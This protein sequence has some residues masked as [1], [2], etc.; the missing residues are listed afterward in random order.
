MSKRP[1]VALI[2]EMSGIYGRQ[3]LEGIARYLRSHR[4]WSV[5][6]EQRELRAPPPPWCSRRH[7][8]GIICRS[9]TRALAR[10]IR[11]QDPDRRSQRS[12]RRSRAAADLVRH[13]GDRPARAPNISWNAVSATS[14]SAAS[15]T[16]PGRPCAATAF[17]MP[18]ASGHACAVYES[19]W[20]GRHVPEWDKDQERIADWIRSLPKPLG[21]MACNDVR[22]Q[23]VLNACHIVDVAVPEEVAVVGVDNEEVLCEL[24]DPPL[25]SVIPN[26]ERI[27]YEAAELL[28]RLMAGGT[29][30]YQEKIVA[31]V[32]R[33]NAAID[34]RLGHRRS[35]RRRRRP[36]IRENACQGVTV[37]QSGRARGR[38]AEPVGTP[39]SQISGPF[40]AR[41]NPPGAASPG[42][43]TAGGDRPV[44]RVDRQTGRLRASGIHERGLQTDDG[45]DAGRLSPGNLGS[46]P[47]M[48]VRK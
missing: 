6:L 22:G 34:R 29:P 16:K 33:D 26:P 19:P 44:A 32:G 14:P 24:C 9:T 3:I 1:R 48:L 13:A 8:D 31:A 42:Q 28:D 30:P 39:V 18:S 41:G 11:R 37:E 20:H 47:A 10:A 17:A 35:G 5:F 36:F 38:L 12:L 40:A 27:G 25:S 2:V 23:Q 7:W 43:A 46:P 15:T 4:P 45:A 21:L